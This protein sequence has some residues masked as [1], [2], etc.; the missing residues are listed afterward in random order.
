[1]AFS[2]LVATADRAVQDHLG[3]TVSYQPEV[4]DAVDVSAVFDERYVRVLEDQE[5]AG[6][7]DVGPAVWLL[8]EDLPVHPDDDEPVITVGG[9][10]YRVRERQIDGMGGI[11][12]FL[13]RELV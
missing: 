12:L 11:R 4:G 13:H 10:A 5:R 1:M 7:E 2:D 9:V 3:G 8:L 6:V